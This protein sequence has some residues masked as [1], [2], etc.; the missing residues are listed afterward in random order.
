MSGVGDG[1]TA[2]KNLED[3]VAAGIEA[4]E[5]SLV[6]KKALNDSAGME[7]KGGAYEDVKAPGVD[8]HHMPADSISPFSRNEGPCIPM[9]PEDHKETLSYGSSKQ[10]KEHRKKQ[11]K[12]IREGKFYE[13]L[14]LDIADLKSE[15]F[16]HKYDEHIK[17]VE[18]YAQK[19]LV[20]KNYLD[21]I[22][23]GTLY[24]IPPAENE[25]LVIIQM[26]PIDFKKTKTFGRCKRAKKHEQ[27][28]AKLIE[29][30]K[31]EDAKKIIISDI[32]FK[33]GDKYDEKIKNM[34]TKK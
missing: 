17:A 8:A 4:A 33:F 10:A 34:E 2:P 12:L 28:I 22:E 5:T 11:E 29:E 1:G 31:I 6:N 3:K 13:A 25:S 32:K 16:K 30:G 26:D 9:D 15:K 14:Q 27:E 21:I 20:S 24:S 18:E 7:I 23:K 19:L